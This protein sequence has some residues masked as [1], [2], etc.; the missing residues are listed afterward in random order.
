MVSLLPRTTKEP[1]GN[2][3]STPVHFPYPIRLTGQRFESSR[4]QTAGL[5]L[6]TN[7]RYYF[8]KSLRNSC[9][10]KEYP[11]WLNSATFNATRLM[12]DSFALAICPTS[13]PWKMY[14]KISSSGKDTWAAKMLAS[15][16]IRWLLI[17]K[18]LNS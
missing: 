16:S 17:S 2:Q 4:L 5:F 6:Y 3:W 8:K 7:V 15:Y 14:S 18:M 1:S 12:S 9:V 13:Y 11:L 10:R